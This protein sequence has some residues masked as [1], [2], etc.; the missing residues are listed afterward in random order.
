MGKINILDSKIY[1]KIAA[2][3]VVERPASVVKELLDN[4]IDAGALDIEIEIKGSGLKN[5]TVRDDGCGIERDDLKLAFLP[6][7]TSKIASESDL[8]GIKTL[9]FR[10]EALP[11]ISAVSMVEICSMAEG[12]EVGCG[13]RLVA[14]KVEEE[15]ERAMGRGTQISISNLFFNTPARLKFLK[16]ERAE[17]AEIFNI[18]S[19]YI[20][21]NPNRRIKLTSN[22]KVIYQSSGL[23]LKDAINCVYGLDALSN[24]TE[25]EYSGGDFKLFGYIGKPSYSKPNRTYQ[26]IALNGRYIV[27]NTISAAISNAYADFLMKRQFPFYV[28]HLSMPEQ[29][30]DVNVHPNKLDVRFEDGRKVFGL[31]YNIIYKT[32]H[33]TTQNPHSTMQNIEPTVNK[34]NSESTLEQKAIESDYIREILYRYDKQ[35]PAYNPVEVRVSDAY[36]PR[37]QDSLIL[38]PQRENGMPLQKESGQYSESSLKEATKVDNIAIQ[39]HGFEAALQDEAGADV[40]ARG[41]ISFEHSLVNVKCTL[42][43]TYIIATYKDDILIVDQHAAHE[44]ILFDKFMEQLRCGKK[45]IQ[46]LLVPF[47]LNVNPS[48]HEFICENIALLGDIGFE[49]DEFGYCVFKV[50]AVPMLLC[51]IDISGFFADLL[52]ETGAYRQQGKATD[53]IREELIKKACRAAVKAGDVLSQMDLEYILKQLFAGKVLLCPHGRPIV[54]KYNRADLEK[55]FKRIV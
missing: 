16:S 29:W 40:F 25:I 49:I 2:G 47:I 55:I 4:S 10:G 45:A 5:I 53:Y 18:V 14:G 19:R 38:F 9:G 37:A 6:H 33:S 36:A 51:D 42:F 39:S 1:N 3:E 43:N 22:G 17:E 50:S 12:S 41:G 8:F 21:C 34:G 35:D 31:F 13:L 46:D 24:I 32:L 54:V 15:F 48:E 44:R 27:N 7:A 30:V 20:L 11:S 23:G 52:K 28:L 26:T